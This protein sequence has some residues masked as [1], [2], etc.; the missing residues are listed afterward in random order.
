MAVERA[1]VFLA[2]WG[3][4]C[5]RAVPQECPHGQAGEG[6]LQGL[7]APARLIAA[8]VACLHPG[9]AKQVPGVPCF[10]VCSL[11]NYTGLCGLLS[12]LTPRSVPTRGG[13]ALLM[14]LVPFAEKKR[15]RSAM[16]IQGLLSGGFS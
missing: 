16:N 10:Q 11:R 6:P 7:P 12:S 9:T 2:A 3:L 15:N 5:P 4:P 13:A 8:A 14:K 1:G